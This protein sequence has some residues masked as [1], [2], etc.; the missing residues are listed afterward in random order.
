MHCFAAKLQLID[1]YFV[2]AVLKGYQAL[3]FSELLI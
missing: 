3:T 2:L 1:V